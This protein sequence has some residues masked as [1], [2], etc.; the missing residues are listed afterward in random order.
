MQAKTA[1]AGRDDVEWVDNPRPRCPDSAVGGV[2]ALE[3]FPILGL[4]GEHRGRTG[5]GHGFIEKI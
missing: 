3:Q 5:G 2:A 1:F 4:D